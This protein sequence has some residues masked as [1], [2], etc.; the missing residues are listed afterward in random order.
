MAARTLLAVVKVYGT[1]I[2]EAY[3]PL[4]LLHGELIAH[5]S[6]QV[7]A[8]RQR[9]AGVDTHS[10]AALVVDALD[11]A[12]DMLETPAQV[13]P[14]PRG[15]LYHSGYSFGLAE[16]E[17]DF[18]GYLVETLLLA[19]TVE[20]AA[21]MEIQH[22]QP[23][24][25]RPPHLVEKGCTALPQRLLVRRAEIDQITVV[26]Q[27]IARFEPTLNKQSLETVDLRLTERFAHPAALVA[28]EKGKRRRADSLGIQHRV[29]HAPARTDVSSDKL[30]H[31]AKIYFSIF[32][33]QFFKM[34]KYAKKSNQQ[35]Q[36]TIQPRFFPIQ[37]QTPTP[38]HRKAVPLQN[39]KTQQT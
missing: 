15:V 13:R 24:L 21:R 10:H 17:I 22:R 20:V 30:S 28:G 18:A 3:H 14:L 39:Q 1:E 29:P 19:D 33:S 32:N 36:K 26:R 37:P 35:P 31:K 16:G 9:V 23:Q 25:L 6:A 8:R 38:N 2:V 5:L 27:H 34:Q 4:E 7:V 11:N 12:G